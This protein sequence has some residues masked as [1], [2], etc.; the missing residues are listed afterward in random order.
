MA[1][2]WSDP[3]M[4]LMCILPA[5][6]FELYGVYFALRYLSYGVVKLAAAMFAQWAFYHYYYMRPGPADLEKYF[7]FKC[8]AT[9]ARWAKSRIPVCTLYELFIEDK[10]AFKGD[11]LET[12]SSP[13]KEEIL[14]YRPDAD[15]LLFLLQQ[16]IPATSSSFK[17]LSATK[18]EIA[19]HYD[20]GNDWFAAFLGE[21]MVYTSG[22]FGP[23]DVTLESVKENKGYDGKVLKAAQENKMSLICDKLQLKQ[24]ETLLDI[25]CG[26]G[27]LARHA[28]KY[29]GAKTTGVTLSVEGAAWC[30]DQ[31]KKEKLTKQCDILEM[32]YRKI[33]ENCGKKSFSKVSSIEM[34]E[35]VGIINFVDPYLK[36]VH[37]ILEDDG[38]FLMQVAGL[39]QGAS[40][41]DVQWGLFM[42]KYIFPGADAST[43][44]NWYIR[45][46]ELA[47]F[48]V[49][50]VETIG[51]HYSHTLHGWYDTFQKAK[52]SLNQDPKKGLHYP[53]SLQRLWD[54]F[55]AYSVVASGQGSATCYQ[56]LCHKNTQKYPRDRFCTAYESEVGMGKH[57]QGHTKK[58]K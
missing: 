51:R 45:Q 34:A 6:A 21:T 3:P 40:W 11:V 26:W 10:L 14:S 52:G 13:I 47:G 54:F 29:Y 28:A 48:E 31:I 9:R 20:R 42:S 32:D 43:P 2:R 25:G 58:A 24:G 7:T 37:D 33:P 41:E 30:N 22:V 57:T 27:T 38:M 18:K 19:E 50:S 53:S 16:F 56:I 5:L 49:R 39:R 1:T 8:E 23:N 4:V 46:L 17:N 15:L 55:L 35:H 44:L 36:T 12:L